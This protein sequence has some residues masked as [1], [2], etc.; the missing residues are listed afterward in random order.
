MQK[1]GRG[2]R[3]KGGHAETREEQSRNNS[4]DLG[5]GLGSSSRNIHNNISL[6]SSAGTKAPTQVEDGNFRLSTRVLEHHPVT[7]PPTNQKKFTHPAA[8][9]PNFAYKNFSPKTI[10]EFGVF[11]HKPP[12]LLAWPCNK[13]FPVPNS[14]TSVYLAS[15][16]L[17]HTNLHL[18]TVLASPGNLVELQNLS[19]TP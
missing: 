11:E 14:E 3:N 10:R 5:Q 19:S 4:A 6:N 15:L 13:P 17:G 16:C 2:C 8:L 12:V 18:V 9:T 7:S 1:Q